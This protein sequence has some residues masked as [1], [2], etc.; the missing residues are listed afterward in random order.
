MKI[1]KPSISSYLKQLFSG[2]EDLDD[3]PEL[4]P[5]SYSGEIENMKAHANSFNELLE[6]KIA[7]HYIHQLP[8]NELE[9][10]IDVSDFY[11]EDEIRTIIQFAINSDWSNVPHWEDFINKPID[12]S[13]IPPYEWFPLKRRGEN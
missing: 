11:D 5:E 7:L 8:M 6:L 9:S 13:N 2:Y 3:M 4:T 12:F 1:N 10:F